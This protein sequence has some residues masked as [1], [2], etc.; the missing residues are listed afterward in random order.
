MSVLCRRLGGNSAKVRH[1]A[2]QRAY[3][4][5]IDREPKDTPNQHRIGVI[6]ARDIRFDDGDE[7]VAYSIYM[8]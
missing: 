4:A 1:I 7:R 3:S 8:Y 5:T 2:I 6:F